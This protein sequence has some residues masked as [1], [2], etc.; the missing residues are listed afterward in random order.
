MSTLVDLAGAAAAAVA[1][2][3]PGAAAAAAAEAGGGAGQGGEEEGGEGRPA[4]EEGA[5]IKVTYSV[6]QVGGWRVGAAYR[7]WRV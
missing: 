3:D 4:A 1:G 7:A 5:R 6:F 2:D